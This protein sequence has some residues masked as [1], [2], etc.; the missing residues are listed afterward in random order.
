MDDAYS[1]DDLYDVDPKEVEEIYS[2]LCEVLSDG[3]YNSNNVARAISGLLAIFVVNSAN[4]LDAAREIVSL[5]THVSL[6]AVEGA[7]RDGNAI[8][9]QKATH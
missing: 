4:S 5:I 1:D 6:Q 9:N 7:D 2:L 8:W 3:E